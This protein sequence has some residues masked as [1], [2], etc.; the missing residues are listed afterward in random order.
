MT[1]LSAAD[2][3]ELAPGLGVARRPNDVLGNDAPSSLGRG[4]DLGRTPFWGCELKASY[5]SYR[6]DVVQ[7]GN[8]RTL[9]DPNVGI[10][11][12]H[13][14]ANVQGTTISVTTAEAPKAAQKNYE[15]GLQAAQ[16]GKF[17]DAE[18]HLTEAT[19][20]FPKYAVAWF[21][22]GQLQ[23][24]QNKSDEAG[25][26]YQK[27]VSADSKYVSPYDQLALLSVQQGKWQDAA[28]FSKQAI[29]LNPVEF[30]SSFWYNTVANYK[31][32][33]DEDT[34]KSA[35]TLEKLDTR[36]RYPE[37]NRVL[38]EMELNKKDY[39]DAAAHLRI[40]LQLVPEAKDADSLKQQ[41]LKIE[42]A[43][44]AARK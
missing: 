5:P 7:L 42:E 20:V 16:K 19:Q 13:R 12:L 41:L 36:H 39:S 2:A 26:S 8:R 40:Y 27:A 25:K 31:L 44:A 10:I 4:G 33:H 9:D 22:L 17:D 38:A 43:N 32:Q 23:Q 30:P 3:S 21:A 34:I 14:L 11:I 18:K 29:T 24:R 28:D 6:S 35:Q 37:I 1:D 15:K